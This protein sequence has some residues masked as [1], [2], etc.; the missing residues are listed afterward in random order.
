MAEP[1]DNKAYKSA[2]KTTSIFGGVQVFNILV[3]IIRQKFIAILLGPKG[4]GIAGLLMST[5]TLISSLTNCGLSTSAVRNI[6]EANANNNDRRIS[7]VIRIFRR[8]IWI[9]GTV[10]S[11]ICL[12]FSRY[13]SRITFGNEDYSIA[14]KILSVSILLLQLTAGQNALLQGLRKYKDLAL[15]NLIGHTVA[16]IVTVPLYYIWGLSAIVPSI[17]FL[18][19]IPFVVAFCFSRKIQ[20]CKDSIPKSLFRQEGGNMVKMGVFISLQ[21]ILSLLAG[22]IV[23][24]YIQ[25]EGG[26]EQVGFYTAGFT[27]INTYVGMIFTAM[28]TEYYPRLS[29]IASDNVAMNKT[30]SQQMEIALLILGPIVALFY[31]FAKLGVRILYSEDFFVIEPMLYWAVLGVV[32]KAVSWPVGFSFLAKGDTK[33]FFFNEVISVM[34]TLMLNILFYKYFGLAGL[35]MSYLLAYII[36]MFQ[37]LT[38]CRKRYFYHIERQSVKYVILIVS[39][40]LIVICSRY[41]ISNIFSYIVAFIILVIVAYISINRLDELIDIRSYLN[42][43]VKRGQN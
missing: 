30:I 1:I 34:Y 7:Y 39:L 11:L 35:G 17:L 2:F 27:I 14:F 36:Y 42:R 3:G 19:A 23:R 9:T 24:I 32:F 28:S 22:Y 18:Y 41:F 12:I 25:R 38:V 33:P 37:V 26:E 40:F 4:M 13:I 5:I 21:H 20:L 29:S 6:A 8:L 16:L 10:G 31:V 43:F 15:A